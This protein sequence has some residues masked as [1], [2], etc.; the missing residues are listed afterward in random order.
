M[1]LFFFVIL[2][3]LTSCSS[4][5]NSYSYETETIKIDRLTKNTFIHKSYLAT[6]DFGNV[7]CN[8]MFVIS[9]GEAIVFETPTTDAGSKELLDYIQNTL[10]CKT[11]AVVA[12]HFHT[13]CLGG[14]AEFHSQNIPSYAHSLTLELAKRDSVT[15]PQN[16]F[17]NKLELTVGKKVV[18]S[19]FFGAG[20]TLDNIVNYVPSDRILFGGCLIKAID[21]SKGYLGDADIN[22]WSETVEKVKA[23]YKKARVVIPGHGDYAGPELL[24]Y[25]IDLFQSK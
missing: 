22:E 20:H 15:V 8:G 5:I 18:V 2:A 7:E 1:K 21:A 11:I 6:E 12:D 19:E 13:D 23:H 9:K 16:G 10:K 24:D 17:E 14:L 25:T 4:L 3:S